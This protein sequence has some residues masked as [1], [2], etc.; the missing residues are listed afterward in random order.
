MKGS[1]SASNGVLPVTWPIGLSLL[2]VI[3][4]SLFSGVT[5]SLA[6]PL[7]VIANLALILVLVIGLVGSA[8]R[9]YQL[10]QQRD[11]EPSQSV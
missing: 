11:S 9:L 5:D 7:N 1:E 8:S 2:L 6:P 4:V 10:L 3:G